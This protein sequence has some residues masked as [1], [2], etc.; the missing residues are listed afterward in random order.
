MTRTKTSLA[1]EEFSIIKKSLR[2]ELTLSDAKVNLIREEIE[3]FE[4]R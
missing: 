4:Q 2:R 1:E 3:D